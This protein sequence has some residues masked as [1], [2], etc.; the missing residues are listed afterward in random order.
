MPGNSYLDMPLRRDM[1]IRWLWR[2]INGNE[3][4]TEEAVVSQANDFIGSDG[5][6]TLRLM[7]LRIPVD[8]GL[9]YRVGNVRFDG[10]TVVTD[11]AIQAM[12][13][14]LRS[15]EYYSQAVVTRALEQ[16]RELWG[17]VGYTDL[18]IFPDLQRR[19][20]PDAEVGGVVGPSVGEE[21]EAD[22]GETLGPD[23]ERTAEANGN[24]G[25]NQY[26]DLERPTHIDGDPVVD[27][28]IRMEEGE[29]QFV[30][31]INFVGNDETQDEVIRRELQLVEN[32]VFSTSALRNSVLRVNQL[33]FFEPFE[34][35]AVEIE[36]VDGRDNSV[37]LT[38]DLSESQSADIRGRSLS[39]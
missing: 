37:D 1:A 8:E 28:V 36:A 14:G 18:T 39:V 35:D 29:Q 11:Y 25:V 4:V 10:N 31:R 6:D 26:A 27:V 24:D 17:S 3:N 38:F 13:G 16:S 32:G 2:E 21:S 7:K 30:N 20:R 23:G 34:E 22:G 33:G 12:F 9:R 19:N 5:D 15:G